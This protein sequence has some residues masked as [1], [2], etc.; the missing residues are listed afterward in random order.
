MLTTI[1]NIGK[2]RRLSHIFRP[3]V[4]RAIIVPTDDLLIFG[5]RCHLSN[6]K[7]K[8]LSLRES[9]VDAIL[10]FPG[11]FR[12]F[13]TEL[14]N[15]AWI[16]NLSV[17]TSEQDHTY[18]K[19]AFSVEHAILFGA[20]AVAVHVNISSPHENEMIEN[21]G[22]ISVQ[23]ERYGIPLMAI[24]YARKPGVEGDDNYE[25]LKKNDPEKYTELISHACRIGVEMGADLI[26]TNYTGSLDSFK[27]IVYSSGNIPVIIAGGPDIGELNALRMARESIEAGGAGICFGRNTFS[28]ENIP[29]FLKS[30]NE[31]ITKK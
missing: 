18:K 15:K 17:S 6:Y 29:D 27:Q 1:T 24:I 20:D 9:P 23:C 28:R 26:K 7:A 22:K 12:E 4:K 8:I 16:I 19:I 14:A 31:I 25:D 5:I 3:D 30:L 13:H 21:L 10:G 2:Q 11:F